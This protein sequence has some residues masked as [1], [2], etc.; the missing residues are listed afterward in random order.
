MSLSFLKQLKRNDGRLGVARLATHYFNRYWRL[1]PT[2]MIVLMIYTN[3]TH[4][5][6]KGPFALDYLNDVDSC[7]ETWWHNLLYINNFTGGLVTVSFGRRF[8]VYLFCSTNCC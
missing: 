8:R 2:Y 4:Y 3:L 7:S 6:I 1:T 5:W